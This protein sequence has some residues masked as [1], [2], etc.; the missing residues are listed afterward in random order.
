M[1]Q[2]RQLVM[3]ATL[4]IFWLMLNG[5]VE[6]DVVASGVIASAV[7]VILFRHSLSFFTEFRFSAAAVKAGFLYYGYFFKALTVANFKLAAI[8][9][10]PALPLN[11][12]LLRCVLG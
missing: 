3:F 4:L 7:I 1:I 10:N 2:L 12:V 11:P 9:L 5:S 6:F 8:V